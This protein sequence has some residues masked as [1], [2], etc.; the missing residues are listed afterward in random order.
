MQEES[1]EIVEMDGISY[2]EGT[3]DKEEWHLVTSGK[4]YGPINFKNLDVLDI[5]AHIGAFSWWALQGG[6]RNVFA[7]EPE[8]ANFGLLVWNLRKFVRVRFLEAAI[9]PYGYLYPQHGRRS[10]NTFRLCPSQG[11]RPQDAIP[12]RCLSFDEVVDQS[13]LIPSETLLKVDCEGGEEWIITRS[14]LQKYGWKAIVCEVHDRPAQYHNLL[15][16][17]YEVVEVVHRKTPLIW[18]MKAY[19]RR[20]YVP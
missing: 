5:G 16:R 13:Y 4:E 6:A 10:T 11:E 20:Y 14:M 15:L 2:R 3:S 19:D 18:V 12:V 1:F 9:G 8:P 7:V 17:F